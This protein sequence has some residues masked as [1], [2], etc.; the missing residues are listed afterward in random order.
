M[1]VRVT[2]AQVKKLLDQDAEEL[3]LLPFVDMAN[4]LTTELCQPLGYSTTRLTMIEALLAA[5][6]FCLRDPRTKS[7]SVEGISESF[8][9]QTGKYLD[10][11]RFGQQAMMMDTLGGLASLNKMPDRAPGRANAL[12]F[13][14]GTF[15]VPSEPPT[16]S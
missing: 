13:S 12:I 5:H 10:A 7:E 9:G 16:S 6:F 8:E 11:T 3:V 14:L 4:E 1:S 15:P 2:F